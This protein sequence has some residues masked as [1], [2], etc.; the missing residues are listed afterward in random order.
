MSKG[1]HLRSEDVLLLLALAANCWSA[2]RTQRPI[3]A[4]CWGP[5]TWPH[6]A[7]CRLFSVCHL[8]LDRT[9]VGHLFLCPLGSSY[10]SRTQR[11]I[12]S[13]T[14]SP[15]RT[16]RRHVT[17]VWELGSRMKDQLDPV[18][19][20]PRALPVTQV[21][22]YQCGTYHT[23]AMLSCRFPILAINLIIL[24]LGANWFHAKGGTPTSE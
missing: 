19:I 15:I 6:P 14:V 7:H 16:I 3:T 4:Q 10:S 23:S 11:C 20:F 2:C 12:T 21:L 13:Q 18:Q 22:N 8:G 5:G 9:I 1:T 24:P 17:P